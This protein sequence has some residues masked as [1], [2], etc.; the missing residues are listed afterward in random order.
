M[1][2]FDFPTWRKQQI[3]IVMTSRFDVTNEVTF[4]KICILQQILVFFYILLKFL[5]QTFGSV[6]SIPKKTGLY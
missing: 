1:N 2:V 5:G 4:G 6:A 3:F